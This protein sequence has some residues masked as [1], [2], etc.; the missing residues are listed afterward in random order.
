[1]YV[2]R[3]FSDRTRGVENISPSLFAN[4]LSKSSIIIL[5]DPGSGK[6]TSMKELA[7]REKAVYC[8]IRDFL[9]EPISSLQNKVLYLDALDEQRAIGDQDVIN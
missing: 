9:V 3:K 7:D 4:F 5:G 1:M 6:T 2:E 8:T